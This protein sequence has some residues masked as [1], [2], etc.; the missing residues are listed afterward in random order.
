MAYHVE[1]AEVLVPPPGVPGYALYQWDSVELYVDA[2]G[3]RKGRMGR[4]DFQI[5]VSSDGRT[6]AFRGDDLLEPLSS[7]VPKLIDSNLPV[8]AAGRRTAT[9]YDV[10]LAVP[11]A[12]LGVVHPMAGQEVALDLSWNDWVADHPQL[13]EEVPD[14][15]TKVAVLRGEPAA[16]HVDDPAHVGAEKAAGILASSYFPWSWS[17]TRDFGYPSTWR[18]VVL[19]GAPALAERLA[20]AYGPLALVLGAVIATAGLSAGGLAG[21]RVRHRRRVRSL[22]AHIEALEGAAQAPI[23]VDPAA[24][25]RSRDRSEGPVTA[26]PAPP[27]S[28]VPLVTVERAIEDAQGE[29]VPRDLPGRAVAFLCRNLAS[30]VTVEQLAAALFVS[31]RTL[32]RVIVDRLGCVP[33]ELIAVVRMREAE[34]LLTIEGRLVKQVADDLGFVSVPHFSR[35]FKRFYGYAPSEAARLSGS[36]LTPAGR[37]V[38][39][40]G[41]RLPM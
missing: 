35:S 3:T 11:W 37:R 21:L 15:F 39:G 9:G 38:A 1:D 7:R 28:P 17:G 24:R 2:K 22:L 31:R 40:D 19:V 32:H 20:A 25:G 12:S 10:E 26:K 27:G 8:N 6:V 4:G 14:L 34:R 30:R 18:P 23:A 5:L 16:A 29:A 33:T 36:H 13:P 41:P